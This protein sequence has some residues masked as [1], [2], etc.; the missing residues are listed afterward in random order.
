M[1]CACWRTSLDAREALGI[2]ASG[3]TLTR[4]EAEAAM[5]SV[6][7]GEA[8]PA[9]LGGLVAALHVRGE[10]PEEIAGFASAMRAHAVRVPVADGAIDVVGTGGDRS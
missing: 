6:M 7:A 1:G 9:Q 8:T 3:R 4:A 10:S 2:V 5:T